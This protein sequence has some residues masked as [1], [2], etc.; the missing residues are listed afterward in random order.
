VVCFWLLTNASLREGR[1]A[2]I[3]VS[4]GLVIYGV[5]RWRKLET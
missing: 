3:A 5:H 1:D 2:A 4:G